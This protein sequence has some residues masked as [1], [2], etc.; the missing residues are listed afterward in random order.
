MSPSFFEKYKIYLYLA[1]PEITSPPMSQRVKT[2]ARLTLM[3]RTK[4]PIDQDVTITWYKNGKRLTEATGDSYTILS[5]EFRDQGLY[6][7]KVF[8]RYCSVM[9]KAATV[10]LT[11]K[12]YI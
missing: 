3:C 11:G 1:P 6:R 9:S 12:I 8:T 2:G 10:S 7:C 4:A 5:V